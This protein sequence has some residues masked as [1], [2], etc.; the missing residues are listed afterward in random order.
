MTFPHQLIIAT[1]TNIRIVL[2]ANVKVQMQS[3]CEST[4]YGPHINFRESDL[5]THFIPIIFHV[6]GYTLCDASEYLLGLFL[7]TNIVSHDR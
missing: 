1:I 4:I 5:F 2:N 7:K 6:L 3:K